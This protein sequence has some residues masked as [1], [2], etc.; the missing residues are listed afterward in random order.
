LLPTRFSLHQSSGSKCCT[1]RA[2]LAE[3]DEWNQRLSVLREVPLTYTACLAA[4]SALRTLAAKAAGYHRVDLGDALIAASAQDVNPAVGVLHYNHVHF[5]KLAEILGIEEVP[6]A[7]P[8]T[9][10]QP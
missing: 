4:I 5:E 1:R 3:F 7:P 2:P 9:F 6:L 10:E 8:G